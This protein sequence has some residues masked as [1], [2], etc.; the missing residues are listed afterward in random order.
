MT[1]STGRLT[2]P[3]LRLEPAYADR[4]AVWHKVS[5]HAP[6]PLMA[7]GAGYEMMNG[8]PLDPWFRKSWPVP[9][10]H[11]DTAISALLHDAPFIDAAARLFGAGVVRPQSLVVNVMGPMDAGYRHVDLPTYRGISMA[12]TPLWF[13]L[14]MGAS[15]L[16]EHWAVRVA[17]VLTWFYDGTGGGYEY[18]PHGLDNPPQC[19]SGPFGNVAVVGDNDLMWHRVGAFGDAQE[20]RDDVSL[21]RRSAIRPAGGGWEIVDDDTVIAML[22]SEQVRVSL[23]WRATTFRDERE[24]RVHDDHE[25]DLDVDTAVSMFCA[26]LTDRG[27]TFAPPDDPLHDADWR[28]LLTRVY[29]LAAYT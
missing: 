19:Q 5:E 13:P 3:P 28:N 23:L 21:T 9:G 1:T 2:V 26:D 16:F 6:Y 10:E 11:L 17:G 8:A 22:P 4:D 20:F 25:D 29:L 27:E 7:A 14:M 18:W 12:R 24:A 15:G